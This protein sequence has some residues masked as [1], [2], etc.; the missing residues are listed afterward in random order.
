MQISHYND[1][2]ELDYME[3]IEKF[4][5]AEIPDF[6]CGETSCKNTP[7]GQTPVTPQISSFEQIISKAI[8]DD[9]LINSVIRASVIL[10][11]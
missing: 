5:K 7:W 6:A 11:Q 10:E 2:I 3:K 8:R 9:H 4:R 1:H